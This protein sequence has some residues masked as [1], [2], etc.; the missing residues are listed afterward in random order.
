ME[1]KCKIWKLHQSLESLSALVKSWAS[2]FGMQFKKY[3]IPLT[4]HFQKKSGTQYPESE[5]RNPWREVQNLRLSWI[6]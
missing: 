2:E 1:K 6:P 5:I 3:E 4:I